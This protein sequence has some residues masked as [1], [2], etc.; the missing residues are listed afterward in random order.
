ME[1][2]VDGELNR[3]IQEM[4]IKAGLE[5][6][7]L[8]EHKLRYSQSMTH[9]ALLQL[10]IDAMQNQIEQIIKDTV[11]KKVNKLCNC[12]S[13]T[14]SDTFSTDHSN[15]IISEFPTNNTTKSYKCD[16]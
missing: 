5:S 14:N 11:D 16:K 8:E 15:H 7:A 13:S 2:R 10:R 6:L 4:Q 12:P 9:N 3:T 1:R